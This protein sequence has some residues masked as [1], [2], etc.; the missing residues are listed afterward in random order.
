MG[1]LVDVAVMEEWVWWL[2]ASDR[3]IFLF[4]GIFDNFHGVTMRIGILMM[5][6]ET[7]PKRAFF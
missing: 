2:W 7:T 1:R 3:R 4:G 5:I 6:T